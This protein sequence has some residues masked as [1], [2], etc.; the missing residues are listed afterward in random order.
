MTTSPLPAI[1]RVSG[2]LLLLTLLVAA[3]HAPAQEMS[4]ERKAVVYLFDRL[5]KTFCPTSDHKLLLVWP[6]MCLPDIKSKPS[7]DDYAALSQLVNTVPMN[8]LTY[9][10]S[11]QK[12]P[13]L[14]QYILDNKRTAN[15]T[16]TAAEE[17]QLKRA[18]DYL[19]DPKT[20]EETPNYKRFLEQQ[21][22]YDQTVDDIVNRS[23][24]ANANRTIA[25][26]A[27][28]L[29]NRQREALAAFRSNGY[30]DE[31]HAQFKTIDTL[32]NR[33]K[34]VWWHHFR[35]QF[36]LQRSR[37]SSGATF[38]HTEYVPD[39]DAW[40]NTDH[41]TTIRFDSKTLANLKPTDLSIAPD[42]VPTVPLITLGS[43]ENKN[44]PGFSISVEVKRV[45]IERPWLDNELFRCRAWKID[46][47]PP[48]SAGLTVH[49][50]SPSDMPLLITS[51]LLARN[52]AIDL[53]DFTTQAE[54]ERT[55][56]FD[57]F[58]PVTLHGA[59]LFGR[60]KA[61]AICRLSGT[62]KDGKQVFGSGI[63][64]P[65]E[66]IIGFICDQVPNSPNPDP[67]YTY[68]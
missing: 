50:N 1:R 12:A 16:L 35:N 62:Y 58:G 24:I 19:H 13:D 42:R 59:L 46:G 17:V 7:L 47:V 63:T 41:W 8:E 26:E 37:T 67:K 14:I 44:L 20:G 33:D 36:A 53:G 49:K 6:G 57:N 21:A 65:G 3:R 25:T 31:V 43:L 45:L 38:P 64:Y 27:P 9:R 4:M 15:V 54:A 48:A 40:L 2:G 18:F 52:I 60:G 29:V 68:P 11:L 32:S 34:N 22:I 10:P 30:Y 28:I 23:F 55:L 66:E 61:D 5:S 56:R 39:L 51:I